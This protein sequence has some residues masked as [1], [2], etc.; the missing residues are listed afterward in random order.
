MTTASNARII[1]LYTW[2]PVAAASLPKYTHTHTLGLLPFQRAANLLNC[3]RACRRVCVCVNCCL[4]FYAA[5]WWTGLVATANPCDPESRK[6]TEVNQGVKIPHLS[7]ITS[8]ADVM[9]CFSRDN[10][11]LPILHRRV[12]LVY[13]TQ[14]ITSGILKMGWTHRVVVHVVPQPECICTQKHGSVLSSNSVVLVYIWPNIQL[15]WLIVLA[16]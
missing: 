1:L 2:H 14:H 8:F 12:W 13:Q 10:D 6:I 3:V 5:M 11:P 16:H 15:F 4:S 9:P 7:K